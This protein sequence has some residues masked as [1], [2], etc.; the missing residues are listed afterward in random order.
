MRM[1]PSARSQ[2]PWRASLRLSV[3]LLAC[4]CAVGP[5][6][7]DP[8]GSGIAAVAATH[9]G[10]ALSVAYLDLG[11]GRQVFHDASREVHAAS[12]MKLAV[13]IEAW[14]RS[15]SGDI[16]MDAGVHVHDRFRSLA[17]GSAFTLDPSEDGDADLYAMAGREVPVRELIRRMIVRS[18]NL[19]TNLLIEL[20]TPQGVQ[21][22]IESLGVRRMQV[23]RGVGDEKAFAAGLNNTTTAEDLALLLRAI[24]EDRAASPAACAAMREVLEAQE[25]RDLIPRGL[26]PGTRCLHKT[27]SISTATHDAALVLPGGAPPFVLVVLT[28][29]PA[30][31]EEGPRAIA[32]VAR[33]AW[34]DHEARH[35]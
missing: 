32:A 16:A 12:T 14:R 1:P 31:R 28:T 17:D 35:P 25:F 10:L 33:A 2:E 30:A 22:T 23:R 9:P 13:M 18:S 3:L 8:L 26:P 27:G 5:G 7:A 29:G 15:E 20:L 24:A 21:R 4:G 11:T 34:R 19:A 6:A